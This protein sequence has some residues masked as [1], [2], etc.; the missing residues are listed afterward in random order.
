MLR[1]VGDHA[2]GDGLDCTS[3]P[4]AATPEPPPAG[5]GRRRRVRRLAVDHALGAEE[6]IPPPPWAA[7]EM[8][9]T[10][11]ELGPTAA[12]G[13]AGATA[14][15][16]AGGA[17]AMSRICSRRARSRGIP[18]EDRQVR[19]PAERARPYPAG[20]ASGSDAD[21]Q[22]A[23]ED[24]IARLRPTG[25]ATTPSSSKATTSS[26]ENRSPGHVN[27]FGDGE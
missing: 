14:G 10:G 27:G 19:A 7:G 4:R 12:S 20:R 16:A 15:G 11:T 24:H 18:G 23:Q 5:R 8:G 3:S 17:A 2:P 1:S 25:E 9:A 13:R 6:G 21:L 26:G 22:R